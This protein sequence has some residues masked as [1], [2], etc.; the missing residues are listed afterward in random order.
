MLDTYSEMRGIR[1]QVLAHVLRKRLHHRHRP[2]E[3][4]RE[5]RERER[6]RE[7]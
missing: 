3:R 2:V 1:E 5:R 6:E 4:E 7:R